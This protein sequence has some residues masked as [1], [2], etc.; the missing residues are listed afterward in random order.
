MTTHRD[1]AA[2]RHPDLVD[3]AWATPSRPDQWWVADFTYVWTLAGS[4]YVSLELP[5][6]GQRI[7]GDLGRVFQR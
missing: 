1:Q 4:V 3:R 7:R 5:P 6:V 2:P